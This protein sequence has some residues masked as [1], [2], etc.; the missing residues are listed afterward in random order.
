[1]ISLQAAEQMR[2]Y[3]H[4]LCAMRIAGFLAGIVVDFITENSQ[5]KFPAFVLSINANIAP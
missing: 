3:G 5:R 2:A 4:L 1:L